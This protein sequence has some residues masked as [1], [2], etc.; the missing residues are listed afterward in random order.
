MAAGKPA[1]A[2]GY[3]G[4]MTFTS[5]DYPFL[6]PYELESVGDNAHPYD[7]KARWA[8]PDLTA[9]ANL[10]RS[11]FDDYAQASQH[12][13]HEKLLIKNNHSLQVAIESIEPLI[14]T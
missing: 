12:A 8:Q 5:P 9:A 4:N 1:I 11:V 10:M 13:E 7:P 3:S 2:T 6:V 14:I